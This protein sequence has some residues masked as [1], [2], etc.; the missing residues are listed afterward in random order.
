MR[1]FL[2]R[3]RLVIPTSFSECLT[4]GQRQ[5]FMWNKIQELEERVE[6]LE[7]IV[8]PQNTE[9]VDENAET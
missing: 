4:Y 8:N 3:A 5:E 9:N 2:D 7:A 1:N 6:A